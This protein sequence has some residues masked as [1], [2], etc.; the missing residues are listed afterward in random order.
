M[1]ANSAADRQSS[2]LR[3]R[4]MIQTPLRSPPKPFYELPRQ[5]F[6]DVAA[7]VSAGQF[8]GVKGKGDFAIL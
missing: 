5:D 7:F 2:A 6:S 4:I 8:I 3:H 1:L